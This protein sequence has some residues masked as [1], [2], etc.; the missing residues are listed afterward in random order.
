M[1][2]I[3]IPLTVKLSDQQNSRK[4]HTSQNNEGKCRHSCPGTEQKKVYHLSNKESMDSIFFTHAVF[5]EENAIIN[6][7]IEN[8]NIE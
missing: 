8:G 7:N 4:Y 6:V 1:A 3:E 2:N 5:N